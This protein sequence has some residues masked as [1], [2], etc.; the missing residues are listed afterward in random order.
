MAYIYILHFDTPLAHARHYT[1]CCENLLARLTRHA[2]G[3]GS[4]LTRELVA[5]GIEWR[6]GGLMQTSKR[7]MRILERRLK[8]HAHSNRYCEVCSELPLKFQ[9]TQSYPIA[10]IPFPTTSAQLRTGC[11]TL[12]SVNV[13]LSHAMETPQTQEQIK[14]LMR[15]DKDALGFIPAAGPQGL[16]TLLPRGRVVLALDGQ[17]LLGYVAYTLNVAQELLTI[18]QCVVK[19]DAR[20]LGIG[21][22]LVERAKTEYPDAQYIA[23]VRD[24]LAAN[25]FWEAIGFTQFDQRPHETS[26][27]LIN[28]Y[29]LNTKE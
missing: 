28:H 6:L 3:A 25:H 14:R 18:H 12:P 7:Q 4:R 9:G 21:K 8:D 1:G 17:D 13:R 10:A 20:L 19:D 5:Q 16:T 2:N 29:H 26:R 11:N 24:D 15:A 27:N 23:K 22:Q